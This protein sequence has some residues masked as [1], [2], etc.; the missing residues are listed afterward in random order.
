MLASR[1]PPATYPTHL[2]VQTSPSGSEA[3]F[4]FRELALDRSCSKQ[5]SPLFN[6]LKG[7]SR[8]DSPRTLTPEAQRALQ[9]V[10]HAPST[11]PICMLQVSLANGIIP[12]LTPCTFWNGSFCLISQK[13]R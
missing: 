2:E 1:L 4:C 3:W 13:R 7:D 9:Q 12:N 10:Q 11:R 5:L 6:I 8:L